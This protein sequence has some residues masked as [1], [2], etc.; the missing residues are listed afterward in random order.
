MPVD[1]PGAQH[2]GAERAAQHLLRGARGLDQARQVDPGLD[3]HL[4][5]HRDD[6][7]AGDVA[8]R[9]RRDRAAAELAEAGLEGVDSLLE[10]G[11]HVGE[12]LAAGVVEVGGELGPGEALAG[13]GEELA[14]LARVGHPGGV[15]EADLGAAGGGE[16]L[17][18]LE[19]PLGRHLALVG[20]A[21]GGRDHALAAQP[22]L[23]RGGEGALEAGQRLL[24][25]AVDVL[26]VVGLGGG[27]EDADLVEA[28]AQV[29]R[30]LEAALVGDQDREGDAVAAL[31]PRPAPARRRR[32]A[33][34]RRAARR[35]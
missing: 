9:A 14:D 31:R 10:R 18:D 34:S 15:A 23:G 30:P 26:A 3:P 33:G 32:A 7:L 27:E 29:E 2:V 22:G 8:G 21:E 20:A 35:R 13:G 12:A 24:D 28:V 16:A 19:D 11:E 5:Q 6:V 1:G 17:G 25:R 4:V